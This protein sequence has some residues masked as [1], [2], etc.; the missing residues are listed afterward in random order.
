[1]EEG[2]DSE[3]SDR[4]E[5]VSVVAEFPD[6]AHF[7]LQRRAWR[8]RLEDTLKRLWQIVHAQAVRLD[9]CGKQT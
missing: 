4:A 6:L 8:L 3:G 5:G 2:G 9:G 1:V 7:S